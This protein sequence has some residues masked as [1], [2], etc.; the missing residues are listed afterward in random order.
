MSDQKLEIFNH[1]ANE[2]I[3]RI[4]ASSISAEVT[5][6][7]GFDGGHL[8]KALATEQDE[9]FI[10]SINEPRPALVTHR[11]P[12]TGNGARAVSHIE[13]L[14]LASGSV[15]LVLS[16]LAATFF[17]QESFFSESLRILKP[18]GVLMFSMLGSGSFSELR[19]LVSQ[20]EGVQFKGEFPDLHSIGDTL[21]KA[22]NLHPVVDIQNVEYMFSDLPSLIDQLESFSFLPWIFSNSNA[23]S[24]E[25]VQSRM[26]ELLAEP[27]ERHRFRVSIQV[28]YGICWKPASDP[29][30]SGMMV[31]F[32]A[33]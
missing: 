3:E 12:L 9:A 23:L 15:N 25:K 31:S 21:A 19:A 1:T 16:N 6:L 30:D 26:A 5:A 24:D 11:P 33:V 18:G 8:E 32:R 7:I 22:Q 10:I 17:H 28:V 13:R 14:P 29:H 4:A 2:L 20:V 27:G